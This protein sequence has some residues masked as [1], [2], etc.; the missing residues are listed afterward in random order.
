MQG[1]RSKAHRRG[2]TALSSNYWSR[3]WQ[4]RANRRTFLRGAGAAGAGAAGFALVG[5]GD[6]DDEAGDSPTTAGG[7][8]PAAGSSATAAPAARKIGGTLR[9]PMEGT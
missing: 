2:K 9:Y 8:S 3:Q 4:E 1:I 7:S 5:C 6:D